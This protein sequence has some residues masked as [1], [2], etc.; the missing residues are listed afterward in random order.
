MSTSQ[1]RCHTESTLLDAIDR[2]ARAASTC[3]IAVSYCGIGGYRFFPEAAVD[4][5]ENLLM[6][7][8]AS[9]TAI[10]RGLTNPNGLLNLLGL[11]PQLRSLAGLHSK[12][13]IFDKNVGWS[14]PPICPNHPS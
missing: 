9:D 7:V 14:A 6:V 11:T 3:R 5:P 12:V 10:K 4:R 13:F 2:L 8:D 1:I